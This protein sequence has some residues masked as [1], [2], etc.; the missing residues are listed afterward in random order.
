[1]TLIVRLV[2]GLLLVAHGLVH[3]LYLTDDVPEF[4]FEDSWLAPESVARSVGVLLMSVTIALFIALGLAVWGV[5]GLSAV[6][7]ALAIAASVTSLVLMACFWSNRLV[8]G[9]LIDVA[10]VAVAVM[11]PQWTDTIG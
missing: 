6:W 7:P 9:V 5:P 1:M 8:I 11:R 3:L 10:I 2:V 4:T